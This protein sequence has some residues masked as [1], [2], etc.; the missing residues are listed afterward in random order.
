M[1][2]GDNRSDTTLA[3][4]MQLIALFSDYDDNGKE[5]DCTDGVMIKKVQDCRNCHSDDDIHDNNKCC[6]G[7]IIYNNE[8]RSSNSNN[9]DSDNDNTMKES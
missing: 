6:D 2:N 3:E 8:N 5:K 7:I 1:T 9:D 4:L